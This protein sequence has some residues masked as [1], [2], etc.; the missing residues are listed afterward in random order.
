[1]TGLWKRIGRGLAGL[2]AVA[3][4]GCASAQPTASATDAAK[5]ALWKVS[6]ADTTV[7]LFGTIHLLPKGLEWQTPKLRDALAQSDELVM[8]AVLGK[9]PM[10]QAQAMMKLGLSPGQPPLASRVPAEKREALGKMIKS[11]G[12][13]AAAL[14]KMETWAAALTLLAVSFQQMD[15]KGD[16]GVESVLQASAGKKPVSGLETVE[17]Q[18][19]YFDGLSEEAQR[20]FLSG[21]LD[22]P[23]AAR[24]EFQA[25]LD[26][27]RRG[28][29]QK[30]AQTFDSEM[31]MTPEL[32]RVLMTQR[33]AAWAEWVKTR[34]DR[35]GT[36][37]VAV[38]AGHLAG[39]DSVQAMLA[40]K[41]LKAVRVQ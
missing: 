35:P 22:D 3:V 9:N 31:T 21:V 29:V 34:L 41:G 18:L 37:M 25:M 26:A 10:K 33:N 5:P 14:D 19:G 28:D 39:R 12:V 17:Q 40:A 13:P 4:A 24:A 11:S 2:G 20:T 30:I 38:G 1:M 16:A 27:W 8:E 6:D 15:L 36:V 7:Y 32:R 23:S